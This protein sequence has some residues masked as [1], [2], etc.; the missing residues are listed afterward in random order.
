MSDEMTRKE[1]LRLGA[2]AATVALVLP[3]CDEGDDADSEATAEDGPADTGAGGCDAG[4]DATISGNHGH[5]LTVPSADITA[6]A[7]AT[8]GIQG[9]ATHAHDV[10]LT[11]DQMAQIA[12]GMSVN[13]T[14][15]SGGGH[16]HQ[17][18]IA[19]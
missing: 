2:G 15:S 8:Y 17:V 6:G 5:E 7:A 16:T 4:A 1:F 10:S 9:S 19:C 13:V 3:A 14:S 12:A 11:A 18:T